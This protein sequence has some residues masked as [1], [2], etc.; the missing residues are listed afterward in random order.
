M[1][2]STIQVGKKVFIFMKFENTT[3]KVFEPYYNLKF[4][5]EFIEFHVK[6]Q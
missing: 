4:N 1:S 2:V 6:L 3:C 5:N